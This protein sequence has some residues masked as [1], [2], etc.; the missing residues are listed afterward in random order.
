MDFLLGVRSLAFWKNSS[1]SSAMSLVSIS[2]SFISDNRFQ[3]V[4]DALL[5][6]TSFF[7]SGFKLKIY[8]L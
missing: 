1:S 2:S 4:F 6:I 7:A 3:S 5:K 8:H